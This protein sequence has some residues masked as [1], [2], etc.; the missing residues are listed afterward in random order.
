MAQTGIP[1][2]ARGFIV[3]ITGR[4]I[5]LVK[6]TQYADESVKTVWLRCLPFVV[7][8]AKVSSDDFIPMDVFDNVKA[9]LMQLWVVSEEEVV[10]DIWITQINLQGETRNCIVY[11]LAGNSVNSGWDFLPLC[12]DWLIAN[13]IQELQ[14]FCRPSAA[15]LFRRR[16]FKTKYEMLTLDVGDLP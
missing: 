8:L 3:T 15:R 10:Q 9:G 2:R 7:E 12:K 4:G 1:A 13:E 16:G 5:I 11:G 6:L 14:A